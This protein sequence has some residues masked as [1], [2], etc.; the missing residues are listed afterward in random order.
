MNAEVSRAGATL[1]EMR[2]K[3]FESSP[4]WNRFIG[5]CGASKT[6]EGLGGR[7]FRGDGTYE[8]FGEQGSVLIGPHD[9]GSSGCFIELPGRGERCETNRC[10]ALTPSR[11]CE[12]NANSDDCV[13]PVKL[14]SLERRGHRIGRTDLPGEPHTGIR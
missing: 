6:S 13:E 8:K 4:E 5:E 2:E 11:V 14:N 7:L 9:L 10:R 3:A 12:G 1:T